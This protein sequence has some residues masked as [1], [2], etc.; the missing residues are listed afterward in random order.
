[1]K[2]LSILITFLLA[3]VI[4]S[5]SNPSTLTFTVQVYDQFPGYNNNFEPISPIGRVIGLIKSTLNSTTRVPELV[6]TATG[7]LNAQGNII[8][9]SLFPYF[10][11]SQQDSSLPGQN[12]PLSLD[13][14]F[15]YDTT[16]NIYIYNNQS[17]FP[18]DYKGF[19]VDPA[20]RIYFDSPNS[21][22]RKYHNYHFCMKMNTVFTYQ[23]YEVF[24]FQG[25][26]D[27]WLFINNK[28]VIDLGGIHTPIIA[29]VDT[30][31]LGLTI[32]KS[33]NFDFFFCERRT[34][35]STIK[36]E[37]NLLFVCPFEDYCGVCQGDGSSCC[38]PLTTCND[39]NKCTIDSCPSANTTISSGSISDYCIHTPTINTNPIDICFNYQCNQSTGNFYPIPIPCLN[40]SS[41]CL[42]TIGCNYI[43]GCQ[44]ES[45]CNS[46]VC[47]IQNQ[48][49]S[50][51]TCI[52]K[53]SNDCAIELDG[54]VDKCKFYSCDSNGVGCIKEDK[55]KPSEDKCQIVS[56]D[57]L[58]GSCITTPLKDPLAGLQLCSIARCNSSTG[59]FAYDPVVCKPSN[60]PCISTHCNATNGQCYETQIPGDICNCGCGILENK[61]KVSWCTPDGICQPKF[62]SEIDDNNSCTFDSC[63][64][65][66]GIISHMTAPQCLSCNQCSN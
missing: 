58:T 4:Y 41:E 30:K 29:S 8:N 34:I 20:K 54:Q 36:I 10:F 21:Q 15:T 26:D 42:S 27:V 43:D 60:N 51:G 45:I 12:S 33:Y 5:Q 23:G 7:G 38:N 55:C 49:S 61:C 19:D 50:N 62:K 6:S 66:T 53:S 35:G 28:L 64:P 17:F 52:P 56:C 57:S 31:T 46:N 37:T 24:N 32:G 63:D 3:T 40:R 48:C 44:Y 59:E 2:L 39:N 25:D 47:N 18:I 9:P 14:I 65:C 13:L 22:H 11:T 16:R 1:M